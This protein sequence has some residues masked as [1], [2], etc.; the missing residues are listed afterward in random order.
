M[1][2]H[3]LAQP[4]VGGD[5]VDLVDDVDHVVPLGVG[6]LWTRPVGGIVDERGDEVLGADGLEQ[7]RPSASPWRSPRRAVPGRGRRAGR[8]RPTARRSWASSVER[9]SVGV[10][11]QPADG[12]ELGG[13]EAEAAHLVEHP[14]DGK[15]Q[16]PAGH[17]ADT[18]GDRSAGDPLDQTLLRRSPC[19]TVR[20]P[21]RWSALTLMLRP[22]LCQG[23]RSSS[24]LVALGC[25]GRRPRPGSVAVVRSRATGCRPTSNIAHG[26]V[27]GDELVA[28]VAHAVAGEDEIVV[29]W[30][31]R[32]GRR[33][34]HRARRR[35]APRRG[36]RR[37]R[38][39]TVATTSMARRCRCSRT[40]SSL[41]RSRG[42]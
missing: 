2:V 28:T 25:A 33:H 38:S 30:A 12:A 37:A 10:G 40:A 39:P 16:A 9:S 41:L 8:R 14:I 3:D 13:A 20:A 23:S 18:P 34:R 31:H 5:V 27:V 32:C 29:E 17:L 42:G 21:L 26:V 22:S 1:R 4:V 15:L 6:E 19:P 7:R 35:R 36:P 24:A 11:R